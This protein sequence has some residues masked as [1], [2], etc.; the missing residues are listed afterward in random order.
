LPNGLEVSQQFKQTETIKVKPFYYTKNLLN[1]K[2]IKKN[3]FNIRKQ[4]RA[5]MPNLVHYLDAA[6]LCLV[7]KNFV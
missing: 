6:S 4:S 5:L 7:I 3:K 1:L 2:V